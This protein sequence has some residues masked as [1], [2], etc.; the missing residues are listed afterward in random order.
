MK[1]NRKDLSKIGAYARLASGH[2]LIT[3]S[4]GSHYLKDG[5]GTTFNYDLPTRDLCDNSWPLAE[6]DRLESGTL[7]VWVYS[8]ETVRHMAEGA[9]ELE[10]NVYPRFE[11]GRVVD[12]TE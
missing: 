11:N 12:I 2:K 6:A 4:V 7:D 3:M 9:V 8:A 5:E 10:C 1:I